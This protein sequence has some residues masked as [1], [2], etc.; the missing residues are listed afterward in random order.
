MVWNLHS[1]GLF[2]QDVTNS[3]IHAVVGQQP[4]SAPRKGLSWQKEL[5][6]DTSHPSTHW[7][8][9]CTPRYKQLLDSP[10]VTQFVR[11]QA[12]LSPL[13]HYLRVV[14]K[15]MHPANGC[16]NLYYPLKIRLPIVVSYQFSS[17]IY[18]R[19]HA[20]SD[21]IEE[22]KPSNGFKWLLL[23]FYQVGIIYGRWE[24]L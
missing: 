14:N 3:F 18:Q 23:V 7:T 5:N 22:R 20:T 6:V 9:L 17:G 11:R 21:L 15:S 2:P 24:P 16:D 8:F 10:I 19:A 12:M 13:F 1:I 4:S